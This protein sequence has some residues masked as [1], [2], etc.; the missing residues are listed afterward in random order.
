M[1]EV[2]VMK[3]SRLA[4]ACVP[5]PHLMQCPGKEKKIRFAVIDGLLLSLEVDSTSLWMGGRSVKS[6][7]DDVRQSCQRS[8]CDEYSYRL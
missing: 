5:R 3:N 6:P 1:N 8:L 7:P 4:F 2:T